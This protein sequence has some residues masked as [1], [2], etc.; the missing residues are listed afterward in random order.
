M[1]AMINDYLW[2][3]EFSKLFARCFERYKG[4]DKDYTKYYNEDHGFLYSIGYKPREF[5]DFVEDLAE[6]GEPAATTAVLIAAVRRDY[7]MTIQKGELSDNELTTDALPP[8]EDELGGYQWLPRIIAKAR[9]KLRG[10]LHP[11]IM[12]GCGGDRNFLSGHGIHP[13]DFLRFV[14][15]AREHD[16]AIV[17]YVAAHSDDIDD[18]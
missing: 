5:F 1:T 4:G 15:A 12:Y 13:A 9:A 10:E 16:D 6:H 18:E 7:F 2:D 3:S 8:R 14:W 17:Q 11:D